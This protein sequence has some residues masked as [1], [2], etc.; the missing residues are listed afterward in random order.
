VRLLDAPD[1]HPTAE[2]KRAVM[3]VPYVGMKA[4][5]TLNTAFTP[6]ADSRVLRRPMRSD[7]F[8]HTTPPNIMPRNVMPPAT[9]K[10]DGHSARLQNICTHRSLLPKHFIELSDCVF[11]M[12]CLRIYDK[13][14]CI[15]Y[16]FYPQKLA[17]TSPTRGGRSVGIVR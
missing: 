12:V 11:Q 8:P 2:Q 7:R 1:T 9:R 10:A 15:I 4:A 5:I 16:P 13:I 17:L 6:R 14:T 3:K